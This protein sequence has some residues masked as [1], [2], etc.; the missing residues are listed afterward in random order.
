MNYR[1][2]S[3]PRFESLEVRLSPASALVS[4]VAA[5]L[6]AGPVAYLFE[7]V[8]DV[9]AFAQA[10]T[11]SGTKLYG[12]FWCSHCHAQKELFGAAA[13]ELPYV[14]C[15]NPDRTQTQAAID[16]GISAYP[17]WV[18]S[19]STRH[20][21]ELSFEQLS[22]LSGVSLPVISAE[23]QYEA[24]IDHLMSQFGESGQNLSADLDADG[25]VDFDDVAM[26]KEN[27]PAAAAPNA[28]QPSAA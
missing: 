16:A 26:A 9:S 5:P 2:P 21:G 8:V 22:S 14:E 20:V 12:A 24:A 28:P 17:T 11:A 15:S 19:N 27:R 25:R 13:A 3:V 6:A 10:L 4:P 1:S 23:T 18:F 7:P